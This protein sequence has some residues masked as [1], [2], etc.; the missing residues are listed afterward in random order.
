[1]PRKGAQKKKP[2]RKPATRKP[3]ARRKPAQ[4]RRRAPQNGDGIIR[5]TY[6]AIKRNA[7]VIASGIV[8]GGAALGTGYLATRPKQPYVRGLTP[9]QYMYNP[10]SMIPSTTRGRQRDYTPQLYPN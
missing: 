2:A 7:P 9:D 10:P 5:D 6:D 8:L 1:M 3:A 4:R